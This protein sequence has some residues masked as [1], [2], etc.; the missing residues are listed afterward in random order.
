MKV[1]ELR[2]DPLII[3]WFK[4]IRAKTHTQES[5]LHCMQEYTNF[6][7]MSPEE[8]ID[9]AEEE[10][11]ARIKPRKQ[12]IKGHI[13]GFRE[14]LENKELA[15]L[16]VENRITGVRSFYKSNDIIIPELQRR[17]STAT[18]LEAH[19]PIPTKDDIRKVLEIA[20][21][22]EK[23]IILVGASS[24]LAVNEICDLKMREFRPDKDK[25]LPNS[26]YD[27]ETGIT[28]LSLRREKKQVDFITFLSPEASKAVLDYLSYR[29]RIPKNGK[30]EYA[31]PLRKQR[32]VYNN[33]SEPEGYLFIKRS[34]D[35]K[36]LQTGDEELR[37][38][39]DF[40]VQE[41]YRM[42]C[43][44]AGMCADNGT[45]NT[46]RSHGLRKFFNN[47][48]IAAK[49]DPMIKEFL[50]GHKI[51]DK[52][53]ASYFVADP[54][55]L[56]ELYKDF[57]PFLTIEKQLDISESPEYLKI[58]QENKILQAE[59]AAHVVERQELQELRRKV[60]RME[61]MFDTDYQKLLDQLHEKVVKGEL[62][63][64]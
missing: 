15:P 60:E 55:E 42:L 54:T 2:E 16:S 51:P 19:K 29:E 59:T 43:E 23:A 31:I 26:G 12:K 9:E 62:D 5:Y 28:T 64:E 63:E 22:L 58:K 34:I 45:R 40:T 47:R 14:H 10:I 25:W 1:A 56:K 18:V 8:L 53:K 46:F 48:L 7:A 24:G 3:E 52:T 49:C 38:L 37:K 50:M 39:N 27:P 21:P 30:E 57:V 32:V 20:D 6:T 41:M 44:K 13:I 33:D 35:D 17:E 36:Y 61:S 4:H 11:E